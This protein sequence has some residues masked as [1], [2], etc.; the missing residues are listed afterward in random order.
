M[1]A[2][3][4]TAPGRFELRDV[5]PPVPGAGEAV[6]KV[7]SCGVCGSDLHFFQGS[8]P[9]PPVCPGHEISGEV[10]DVGADAGGRRAGDRVA[11]EPLVV[12]RE[13]AYCRTGDYQLCRDFRVVG[14]MLDGGFAD[15]LRMPAY[16]LFP[17]PATVDYEVG[18]LTE[19]LAVAVH[20][21]R[22]ANVRLGDRV[23]VLGAGTIGLLSVAAAKAAGAAEVWITARH[24]HQSAAATMLGATRVFTGNAAAELSAAAHAALIDVVIETVGGA[25][26]TMNDAIQL[27]RP[28]G[29]V[30]VLGV[31]TTLPV[32]NALLLVVKEVRM[33]G[34]LTYGRPGPRA[35]FDV[36]LQ[37]LAAQPETFRRL[38]THRFPLAEITRGFEAAA[39]KRSGSIKVAIGSAE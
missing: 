8:F 36:A 30:A 3:F 4:C 5:E 39:D 33:V 20:G 24:P 18:A 19:P 38:I 21:V 14:M 29:C 6:I 16:A 12:C 15:Y 25:A 37:L 13:C 35:D 28:A 7:R 17:L 11:I 9:R 2:A 23:L 10:V 22:L 32:V 27:V 34:S 26:D 1:H 31:F